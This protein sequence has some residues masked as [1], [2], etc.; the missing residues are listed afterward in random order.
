[1]SVAIG[2]VSVAVPSADNGA[3]SAT[4]TIVG[5]WGVRVACSWE[6]LIRKIISKIRFKLNEEDSFIKVRNWLES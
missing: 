1:M 6:T 5:S 4:P 2:T 3:T